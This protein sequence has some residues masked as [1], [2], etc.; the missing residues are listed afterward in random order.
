MSDV[1]IEISMF[2]EGMRCVPVRVCLN[3]PRDHDALTPIDFPRPGSDMLTRMVFC[4]PP[5]LIALLLKHREAVA[6]EV[7]AGVLRALTRRDTENGY[8]KE[9]A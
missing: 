2:D 5:D 6:R 8:K 3:L 1:V 9:P 4:T 7:S